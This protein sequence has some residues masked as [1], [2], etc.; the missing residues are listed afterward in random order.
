MKT[1]LI[2]TESE[3]EELWAKTSFAKFLDHNPFEEAYQDGD[4]YPYQKISLHDLRN[5]ATGE[6]N[7]VYLLE[8]SFFEDGECSDY[9]LEM[10]QAIIR[11]IND[12]LI[13][14]TYLVMVERDY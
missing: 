13:P 10:K 11:W 3:M 2:I 6:M 7:P 4:D 8:D 14:D 5:R 1:A 9:D 12:R